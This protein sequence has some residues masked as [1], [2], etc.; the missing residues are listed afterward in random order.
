ML[1]FQF[2]Q[3]SLTLTQ[4]YVGL[5]DLNRNE[6]AFSV[7][8]V[9]EKSWSSASFPPVPRFGENF[10]ECLKPILHQTENKELEDN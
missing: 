1:K 10:L 5:C 7:N 9:C 2:W 4:V 8:I 6:V 3:H